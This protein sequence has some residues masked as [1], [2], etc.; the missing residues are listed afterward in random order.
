MITSEGQLRT[1]FIS[2]VKRTDRGDLRAHAM[3]AGRSVLGWQVDCARSLGCERIVCLCDATTPE[4]LAQQS[5]VEAWGAEFHAIRGNL[6]LASLVRADDE[7]VM[8]LDGLVPDPVALKSFAFSDG[9]LVKGIATIPASHALAEAY[10][11]DFERIDRDRHWAGFAAMRAAQVHKLAD[12]PPDSDPMSL[13]IRLGLQSRVECREV[14]Q[15]ALE[16]R[17]WLLATSQDGLIER[18]QA[19]VSSG[20]AISPLSAPL[21]AA[22]DGIV[23]QIAP[24]WIEKGGEVCAIAGL[25]LVAI[26]VGVSGFGY[27]AAGLALAALG[28]FSGGLSAAWSRLRA[29]LWFSEGRST[30][31]GQ[32]AAAMDMACAIALTLAQTTA[33][34]SLPAAALGPLAIGLARLAGRGAS[35]GTGTGAGTAFDAFW[36]DRALQMAGFAIAATTGVL[37]EVL[38]LFSLGALLQLMLRP[39]G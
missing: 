21:N 1:A 9:A 4:V 22:A 33:G 32:V 17:G 36:R 27:G 29:A 26:G 24:R 39:R 15:A 28:A 37:A 16:N 10:P 11:D 19:L 35:S 38:A 13:L 31:E 34:A 25:A 30:R 14:P 20:A 23:R 2:A 6:Q 5:L 7:L 8:L 12:L 3:M 18:E